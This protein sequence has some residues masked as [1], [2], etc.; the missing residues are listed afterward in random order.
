[1]IKARHVVA[2]LAG[3]LGLTALAPNASAA[4]TVLTTCTSNSWF[5]NQVCTYSKS[6]LQSKTDTISSSSTVHTMTIALPKASRTGAYGLAVALASNGTV[7]AG[8]DV[9]SVGP[10]NSRR[11]S[12]TASGAPRGMRTAIGAEA[13]S[14]SGSNQVTAEDTW[15]A[16][17]T[18]SLTLALYSES[19]PGTLRTQCRVT[20]ASA[21]STSHTM[22]ADLLAGNRMAGDT[23]LV[24]PLDGNGQNA[25]TTLRDDNL[26]GPTTLN[27]STTASGRP[28]RLQA[29]SLASDSTR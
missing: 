23:C 12:T 4:F 3:I 29:L 22:S 27:F 5:S 14:F 15:F 17:G 16:S 10:S 26:N 8:S 28:R 11:F 21:N 24:T 6:S 9:D 18:Q 13:Q 7:I 1:M 19:H 2:A 25:F 20:G